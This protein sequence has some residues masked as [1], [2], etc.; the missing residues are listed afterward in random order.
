MQ[1]SVF[2]FG[3]ISL[4]STLYC[5]FAR[6]LISEQINWNDKIKQNSIFGPQIMVLHQKKGSEEEETTTHYNKFLKP[7][8]AHKMKQN[9]TNNGK[10]EETNTHTQR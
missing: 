10:K 7:F 3:V 4:L 9:S 2:V 1:T 8:S 5:V 6:D